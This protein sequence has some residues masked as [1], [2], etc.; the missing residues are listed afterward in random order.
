M[1]SGSRISPPPPLTGEGEC[2]T[3]VLMEVE[4]LSVARRLGWNV[5]MRCA[6]GYRESTKSTRRC[7]FRKQL[8]LD[9]LVCTRGPNFPLSRLES[10]LMCASCGGRNVTVVLERR[11]GVLI[12]QRTLNFNSMGGQEYAAR[13]PV[14]WITGGNTLAARLLTI[15]EVTGRSD[16]CVELPHCALLQGWGGAVATWPPAV[17]ADDMLRRRKFFQKRV[18]RQTDDQ[19]RSSF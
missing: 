5:Y 17:L 19:C 4:T 8:E 2:S 16:D 18:R 13:L 6:E 3:F 7:V 14:T 10:R 9:T 15:A 12:E 1:E 11:G